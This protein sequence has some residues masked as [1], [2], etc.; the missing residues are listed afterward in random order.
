MSK[1]ERHGIGATLVRV[2]TP[3]RSTITRSPAELRSAIG[4]PGCPS[5][6]ARG[7]PR[8]S[9]VSPTP[10]R[11]STACPSRH[12]RLHELGSADTLVDLCGAFLLLDALGVERVVLLP[13]AVRPES[14]RSAHG[15]LPSP[16]PAVLALLR[17]ATFVG[18]DTEAE[19]VT[20]TG[21]A[22]AAA[23]QRSGAGC[24]P[25]A[26][27]DRA[28]APGHASCP[29]GRTCCGSCSARRSRAVPGALATI[30]CCEANLDDLLPELVPDA[31]ERC[32]AAGALDVW[33]TPVQ[34]KKGRPGFILSALAGRR[35]RPPSR[36]RCW[37]TR[38]RWACGSAACAATS[39]SA[40]MRRSRWP[41]HRFGSARPLEGRV[42]N[43]AP[44]H[45]DC[46]RVA[47]G[48][49]PVK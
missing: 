27:G 13:P 40:R 3:E 39:W 2:V 16:A 20:P 31:I 35:P 18:V 1:T 36:G 15:V 24:R 32:F 49:R 19:L 45:D 21:A 44:E 11:R 12:L 43:V 26:G 7:R 22:I 42:V 47:A 37:N 25:S 6:C 4:T 10:R 17:G 8:R 5:P 9:T 34:M 46:A 23:V 29:T 48:G 41:G 30:S 38:P 33:T 14:L 28:T